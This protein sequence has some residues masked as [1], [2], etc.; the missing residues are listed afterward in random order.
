MT[1]FVKTRNSSQCRTHHQNIIKRY[2]DVQGAV[3]AFV[4]EN[5]T[6]YQKYNQA[7]PV[8]ER[9]EENEFLSDNCKVIRMAKVEMNSEDT[10]N[11]STSLRAPNEPIDSFASLSA[12][13]I[14]PTGTGSDLP[15]EYKER[16]LECQAL[17]KEWLAR[18]A[19]L[20]GSSL[21]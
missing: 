7:R 17:F 8:L 2:G 3:D 11:P 19:R 13:A 10:A 14:S 20:V 18:M 1:K 15:T 9:L 6:F 12:L 5:P 21:Q 16:V 4:E